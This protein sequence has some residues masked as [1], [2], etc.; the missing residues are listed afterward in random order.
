MNPIVPLVRASASLKNLF[1]FLRRILAGE[2]LIPCIT[3]DMT[4]NISQL[5]Q[6]DRASIQYIK[7]AL[8]QLT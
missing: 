3:A 7:S 8:K 6:V 2:L 5:G 1:M 4:N